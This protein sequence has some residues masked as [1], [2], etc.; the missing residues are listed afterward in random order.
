[1]VI[2]F[3]IGLAKQQSSPEIIPEP[4]PVDGA[5]GEVTVL[6]PEHQLTSL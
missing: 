5:G 2:I 1:M 6:E 3:K 4:A